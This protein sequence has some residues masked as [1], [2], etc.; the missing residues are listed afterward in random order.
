[1]AK[2]NGQQ[3]TVDPKPTVISV[4]DG[5]KPGKPWPSWVWV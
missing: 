1:M 5:I 2:C 3:T 4:E